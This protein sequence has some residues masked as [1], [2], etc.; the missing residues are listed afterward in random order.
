MLGDE[1]GIVSASF[2]PHESLVVGNVLQICDLRAY[3]DHG[4]I[5]L[6]TMHA[7]SIT[8]SKEEIKRIET[9]NNI[10]AVLYKKRYDQ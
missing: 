4:H 10:S 1:S 2:F 8:L 3:V 6:N 5:V 9:K 7:N